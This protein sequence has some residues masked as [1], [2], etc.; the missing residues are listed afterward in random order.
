M[1]GLHRLAEQKTKFEVGE[2][3]V[4]PTATAALEASGRTV[5]EI[6]ARHR[7]GDWGEVSDQ[8]RE[9]NERGLAEQFNVQSIYAT[10]SGERLVVVTTGDRSLTMVHLAP[11]QST[12]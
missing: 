2:I 11:Q 9:V 5:D 4:T 12:P 7:A 1:A 8:V 6:V 10:P 3:I